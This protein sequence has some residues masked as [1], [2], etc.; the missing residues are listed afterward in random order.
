LEAEAWSP[1]YPLAE[2]Q[3]GPSKEEQMPKVKV[4]IASSLPPAVLE[5]LTALEDG[6]TVTALSEPQRRTLRQAF[7]EA[8]SD[9]AKELLRL[10]SESEVI[11]TGFDAPVEL[12][13]R[14]THARW[15]HTTLAGVDDLLAQGVGRGPYVFTNGSGPHAIS[16]AE[17]IVMQALMMVKGAHGYFRRQAEAKWER[18][19]MSERG[20]RTEI[21]GMTAGI[22]GLGDIGQAA[23]ERLAAMG[24]HILASRR[25]VTSRQQSAGPVHE[26]LPPAD[27][28]YLLQNSDIVVL[29]MPLTPETRHMINAKTLDMMKRSAYL[30]NIARGGVIDEAALIEALRERRIAGAAL[31]VFEQ[32]PLPADSPLWGMQNVI[33]TPHISTTS[34]HFQR[35]QGELFRENLRRYLAHEP[36]LN[37]VDA[38]RGY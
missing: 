3:A 16:I 34:E 32:E 5:Q 37:V 6:V 31:D 29:S 12:Y 7:G 20:E 1:L 10:V 9:E 4:L 22:I 30:I 21:N 38:E 35:R 2:Q 27:L 17:H 8:P 36:L 28:P 15:I 33:I 18:L 23:A 25:S 24:C 13:G 14:A 19:P 11:F 26:L